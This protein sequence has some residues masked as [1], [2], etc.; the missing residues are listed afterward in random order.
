MSADRV[1]AGE[2]MIHAADVVVLV[3]QRI[4]RY[5]VVVGRGAGV[6]HIGRRGHLHHD[7]RSRVNGDLVPN[8]ILMSGDRVDYV[9]RLAAG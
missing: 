6:G 3:V 5:G 9:E 2:V 1:L 7:R 4:D 8:L